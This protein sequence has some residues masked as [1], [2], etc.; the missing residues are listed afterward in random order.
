MPTPSFYFGVHCNVLK[1]V[2]RNYPS[3]LRGPLHGRK[4][5]GPTKVFDPVVG[6]EPYSVGVSVPTNSPGVLEGRPLLPPGGEGSSGTSG[7]SRTD[8]GD[9]FLS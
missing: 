4:V 7:G 3:A 5:K 6:L 2:P 9:G 1:E 8:V